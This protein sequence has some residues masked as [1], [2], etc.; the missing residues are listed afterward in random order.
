MACK[1][2]A[3]LLKYFSP[4]CTFHLI[5]CIFGNSETSYPIESHTEFSWEG[6]GS[7]SYMNLTSELSVR[8]VY[9]EASHEVA[10]S[11]DHLIYHSVINIR[12]KAS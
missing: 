2:N 12:M 8:M 10:T 6:G 7:V 9:K 4:E 1:Y 5:D 11:E 3:A